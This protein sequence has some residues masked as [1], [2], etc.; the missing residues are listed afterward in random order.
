MIFNHK[1]GFNIL[2]LFIFMPVF[3]SKSII[4]DRTQK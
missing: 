3:K 2:Y 1:F 4:T